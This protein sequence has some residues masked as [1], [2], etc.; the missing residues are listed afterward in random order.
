MATLNLPKIKNPGVTT[1]DAGAFGLG[2][3]IAGVFSSMFG[4]F[5]GSRRTVKLMAAQVNA[6]LQEKAEL[7]AALAEND[8]II[9]RITEK[10]PDLVEKVLTDM[11]ADLALQEALDRTKKMM[12]VMAQVSG[13]SPDELKQAQEIAF[14]A[15]GLDEAAI[16]SLI[17]EISQPVADQPVDDEPVK[18]VVVPA[19]KPEAA[20]PANPATPVSTTVSRRQRNKVAAAVTTGINEATPAKKEKEPV[21]E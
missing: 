7:E 5:F 9:E 4:Y 8:L 15:I 2:A 11:D 6:L 10:S 17:S 19:A 16:A 20:A 3:S 13:L 21:T 18:V 12:A 1:R 14:G